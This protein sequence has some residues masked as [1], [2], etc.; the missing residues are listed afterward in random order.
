MSRRKPYIPGATT[1]KVLA[2]LRVLHP[3]ALSGHDV[4]DLLKVKD[5]ERV[6]QQIQKALS[7]LHARGHLNAFAVPGVRWQRYTLRKAPSAKEMARVDRELALP[8]GFRRAKS[9]TETP[10]KL[11]GPT[12]TAEHIREL[13]KLRPTQ[14]KAPLTKLLRKPPPPL[15]VANG[16][17]V[18][19]VEK[20]PLAGFYQLPKA[21]TTR[22]TQGNVEVYVYHKP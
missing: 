6:S 18:A 5:N 12:V 19:A 13:A 22:I 11:V 2:V 4:V 16:H 9:E 10:E 7:N 1:T 21:E 8:Y 17:H 15:Q 20:A 14:D 3:D